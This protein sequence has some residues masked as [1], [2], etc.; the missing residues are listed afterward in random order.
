MPSWHIVLQL[1]FNFNLV[2]VVPITLMAHGVPCPP[3]EIKKQW[4]WNVVFLN[5]NEYVK[6]LH[7][8]AGERNLRPLFSKAS[9]FQKV[10]RELQRK[11][12]L[13]RSFVGCI[14]FSQLC[15][16]QS[17]WKK[18]WPSFSWPIEFSVQPWKSSSKGN[19]T[20]FPCISKKEITRQNPSAKSWWLYGHKH[21]LHQEL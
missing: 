11:A 16:R 6:F 3:M 1:N 14:M 20:S 10:Y 19:G 4:Q 12:K 13:F 18:L 9:W 5:V 15:K 8:Y 2:K 21:K 7:V 17:T